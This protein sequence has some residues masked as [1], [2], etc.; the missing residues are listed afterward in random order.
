MASLVA[1]TMLGMTSTCR[2]SNAGQF[3]R[4]SR[5]TPIVLFVGAVVVCVSLWMLAK[6]LWQKA[7]ATPHPVQRKLTESSE[8]ILSATFI[9]PEA[10]LFN[11]VIGIPMSANSP[12]ALRGRLCVLLETNQVY[13]AN[14]APEHLKECNW[15][16]QFGMRGYILTW[17]ADS[18]NLDAVLRP[19]TPYVVS[20]ELEQKPTIQIS[21][22]LTYVQN[23]K[24]YHQSSRTN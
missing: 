14:F 17:Q 10:E 24:T 9:A 2:A 5:N 16:D 7:D 19:G 15:L 8:A 20:C 6:C 23:W 3:S 13:Q 11:L 21:L 18:G 22:W 12:D 4:I 1:P